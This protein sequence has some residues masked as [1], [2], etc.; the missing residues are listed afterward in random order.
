MSFDS[1]VSPIPLPWNSLLTLLLY[2]HPTTSP[3][4]LGCS[5]ALLGDISS[6]LYLSVTFQN[7]DLFILFVAF[8][9][10]VYMR[11]RASVS[12]NICLWDLFCHPRYSKYT[13]TTSYRVFPLGYLTGTSFYS[14][15]P[16]SPL[17]LPPSSP[18]FPSFLPLSLSPRLPP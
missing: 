17:S 1:L 7:A 9:K 10:R 4:T 5:S 12:T 13:C 18:S 8:S 6:T 16:L 3:S 15:I 2:D 11:D 14:L